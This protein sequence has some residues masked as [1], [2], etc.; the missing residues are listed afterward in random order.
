MKPRDPP[1]PSAFLRA[2]KREGRVGREGVCLSIDTW[3]TTRTDHGN[4]RRR[5]GACAVKKA[6]RQ[7][8]TNSSRG[9]YLMAGQRLMRSSSLPARDTQCGR[10]K[11]TQSLR[12]FPCNNAAKTISAL[13]IECPLLWSKRQLSAALL[14]LLSAGTVRAIDYITWVCRQ[15]LGSALRAPGAA[16]WPATRPAGPA[17]SPAES[18]SD[19]AARVSAATRIAPAA[20][21][22]AVPARARRK[23]LSRAPRNALPDNVGQ[24]WGHLVMYPSFR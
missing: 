11:T 4:P 7:R 20:G 5:C 8:S 21:L 10:S 19:R 16:R 14:S 23:A 1:L 24:W 18:G 15:S 13:W 9:S 2:G 17:G 3:A 22:P 6:P 12:E